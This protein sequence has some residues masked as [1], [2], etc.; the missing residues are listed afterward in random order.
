VGKPTIQPQKKKRFGGAGFTHWCVFSLARFAV[1]RTCGCNG[2]GPAISFSPTRFFFA[3][4]T[5]VLREISNSTKHINKKKNYN[6]ILKMYF[7]FNLQTVSTSRRRSSLS[8]PDIIGCRWKFTELVRKTTSFL[9][10]R[11]EE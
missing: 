11:M 7:V 9:E 4:K 10:M 5:L 2:L 3:K 6:Q 1:L 8:R